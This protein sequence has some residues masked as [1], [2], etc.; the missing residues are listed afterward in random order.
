MSITMS[1][2]KAELLSK[3]TENRNKHGEQFKKARKGWLKE[4]AAE[5]EKVAAAAKEGDLVVISRGRH[6]RHEHPITSVLFEEPE[7]HTKEYDRIIE[8]LKMSSDDTIK[9]TD[10]QFREYVQ[11]EWGWKEEWAASNTKYIG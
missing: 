4:V 10:T 6:T 1:F 8:M 3:L 5:C 9:I 2:K 11:D 7:D